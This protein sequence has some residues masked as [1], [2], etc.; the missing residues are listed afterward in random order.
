[1]LLDDKEEKIRNLVQLFIFE[2][3]SK[4][5]NIIYNLIPKALS[6][7]SN[8]FDLLSEQKYENV[9]KNLIKYIE[10]DKQTEMLIEKLC[11]KFRNSNSK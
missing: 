6:R 9:A 3:N 4:G 1:M 7:M 2:L 5:N 10:K 11:S 8:E